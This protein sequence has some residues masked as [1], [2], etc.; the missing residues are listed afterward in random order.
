MKQHLINWTNMDN[1][2]S[3]HDVSR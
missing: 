3:K 1:S 2:F